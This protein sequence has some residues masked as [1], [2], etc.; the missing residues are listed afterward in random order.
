MALQSDRM[1]PVPPALLDVALFAEVSPSI[2]VIAG[3]TM[4]VLVFLVFAG[5]WASRFQ[6]VGP[7]EVLVVSGRQYVVQ[8][9]S[10]KTRKT[11]FRIVRG[12]GGTFIWPI[13]ETAARLSLKP[14]AVE[15]RLPRL[16]GSDGHAADI[17]A[18][19]QFRIG[20]EDVL[21]GKAAENLLGKSP[22]EVKAIASQSMESSLRGLVG[23]W[24]IPELFQR[25]GQL[26]N[27][28]QEAARPVLSSMGLEIVSLSVRDVKA[29]GRFS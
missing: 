20:S 29:G 2:L 7:D 24:T 27:L 4:C 28:W 6:K 21:L 9:S 13:Y 15:L 19:A 22:D 3:V 17:E 25:R 8:D 16:A 10:G 14:V 23:T 26:G 12:G 1:G 11:G 5:I 18:M